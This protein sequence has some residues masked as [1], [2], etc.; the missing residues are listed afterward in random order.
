MGHLAIAI[1]FV[2]VFFARIY[3]D[4]RFRGSLRREAPQTYQRLAGPKARHSFLSRAPLEYLHLM[5]LRAYR[6]ELAQCPASRAW[7]S[8]ISFLDWVMVAFVAAIAIAAIRNA[9]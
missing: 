4:A 5:L 1:A 2:A 9:G 7:A 6:K 8:W 3:L